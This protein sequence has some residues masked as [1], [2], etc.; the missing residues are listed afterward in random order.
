MSPLEFRTQLRMQ[1]ARRIMVAEAIDAA[2]AGFRVGYESPSQFSRDYG[3]VF[4]MPPN[5]DTRRLRL[6]TA[7]ASARVPECAGQSRGR[8]AVSAATN[9]EPA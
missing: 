7:T 9:P 4:G 6:D 2:T 8:Q 3:R 1:E 5:K